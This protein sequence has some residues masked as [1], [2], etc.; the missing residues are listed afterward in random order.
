[1]AVQRQVKEMTDNITGHGIDNHL[2][3]LRYAAIEAGEEIPEI[4]TDEAYKLVNHFA[5]STSQ[6]SFKLYKF[7]SIKF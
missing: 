2:M 3:G 5:L 6:V 7:Q 4:L 1:M